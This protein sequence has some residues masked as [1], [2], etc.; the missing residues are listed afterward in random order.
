MTLHYHRRS[1]QLVPDYLCYARTL[2]YRDKP[3]QMIP[4][5]DID[6]AMGKLLVETMTPMTL[7]LSLAV[8]AELEGRLEQTDRLRC[9][10]VERAEHEAQLARLRYMEVDPTQRLVAASLEADWNE[11]LRV[12]DE[13]RECV[14]R[15]RQADQASFDDTAKERIR[16]LAADFPSVWNDPSIHHRE[17][18]VPFD[19]KSARAA[20]PS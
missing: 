13:I 1:D 9:Q 20:T 7:D 5:G 16:S 10:Q 8:Q 2:R 3:C 17:G 6:A 18:H 11:K 4:G 14:E 12:L 15:E 19:V